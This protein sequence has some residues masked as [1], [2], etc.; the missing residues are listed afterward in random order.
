MMH[1]LVYLTVFVLSKLFEGTNLF[2]GTLV[3]S[4]A[5]LVEL[6][7]HKSQYSALTLSR[8]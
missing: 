2:D 8:H 1:K 3:D 4:I 6:V 5:K 7:R